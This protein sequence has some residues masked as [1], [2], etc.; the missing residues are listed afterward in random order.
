M[1]HI[2]HTL[3][4]FLVPVPLVLTAVG[5]HAEVKESPPNVLFIAVDDLNDFPG[6][7]QGS[8]HAKTPN[9]DR[10]AERG[11][12]FT[13]AHA[14]FPLCGPS[15]ASFMSGLLPSTLAYDGHMKDDAV[16]ERAREMGTELLHRT[17][18]EHGYSTLAV[19]KILHH[20]VPKGS[21]DASGGRLQFNEGTGRLRRNWDVKGTQTDWRRNPSAMRSWPITRPPRGRWSNCRRIRISPFS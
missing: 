12:V 4:L 19:G 14:Q 20:H 16:E 21:V 10:L 5:C 8:V 2:M 7:M 6:F 1:K 17:F 18:A 15:R 11:V 9:L 13:R 3:R